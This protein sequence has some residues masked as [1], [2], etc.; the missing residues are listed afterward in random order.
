MGKKATGA[1]ALLGVLVDAPSDLYAI[2]R[3]GVD[4]ESSVRPDT[5]PTGSAA[6]S[7]SLTGDFLYRVAYGTPNG[8]MTNAGPAQNT[9]DSP[10]T[11]VSVAGTN[12]LTAGGTFTGTGF[13]SYDV[14]IDSTAPDKYKWRVT[15]ASTWAATG[16]LCT[17]SPGL[18]VANGVKAIFSATTGAT[19]ADSWTILVLP[20]PITASAEH[21]AL[22]GIETLPGDPNVDRRII[23][24]SD[25]GGATWAIVKILYDDTTVT[26]TDNGTETLDKSKTTP[27]LNQ[28]GA[29][30]GFTFLEPD[31]FDLEPEFSNLK[32][33]ALLGTAGAPRAI[34]GPIKVSGSPK[35][36][37]RPADLFPI[38]LSGAG[39]PDSY[40]QVAGEPTWVAN[41]SATTGKRTQRT[42]SAFAYD[43]SQDVVPNFLYQLACD[44]LEFSFDGG[45][46]ESISP[47]FT[48]AN[49][50]ISPPGTKVAVGGSP[51]NWA[52][53]FA[54]LGQRYDADALTKSV[55]VKI[56][57]TLSA[58][59]IK[60]RVRVDTAGGGGGFTDAEPVYTMYLNDTTKNQTKGGT[61][62]NDGI[63]IADQNGIY[64]GADV[65]SNRQPL[66]LVATK[67]ITT[68]DNFYV[69]DIY[70][71]P[72]TAL[73]PGVGDPP[74]SGSPARFAT[75]PRFTDAHVTIYQ[76]GNVIEATSGKLT[77][78]WPKKAV[79]ALCAGARTVQ[80][81]PNEGFF[82][83]NM[84]IVRYL[85]SSTY[86][87]VIRT[88]S[89]AHINIALSGERIPV[90]PGT[91][92][93]HRESLIMDF[94]QVVFESVKA[95]V[96]GQVLVVETLT[97]SAEQPD[98][99]SNDLYTLALTT[100]Q[101]WRLPS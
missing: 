55:F 9:I 101:G 67:P 49:Y 6:A 28:T 91:L 92:S 85:D 48:G 97:A 30:Y 57:Q 13:P 54:L 14:E 42:I 37:L 45:K 80:D 68:A 2:G 46:I 65:G 61:Q 1:S 47:K 72:S 73:I 38:I 99:T 36:D 11:I 25:D 10:A 76:D 79:N 35:S 66:L 17:V 62:F 86:R 81:L 95:P 44:Q 40:T 16:V 52:G 63:E 77:L 33:V 31:S 56:T 41:W 87:N 3:P 82:A 43:G 7:G 78:M 23:E 58:D 75:G 29:N 27:S 74:F 34:P 21:I 64:L 84:S 50:G 19:L 15:G 96:T 8:A 70:E 53:N 51:S 5:A 100:R 12:V 26:W 71:I 39:K 32:V 98:N 18:D 60:F 69:G 20:A 93:T 22:T 94:P 59:T 89:R 90:S 4:L 24:R 83:A 88:D